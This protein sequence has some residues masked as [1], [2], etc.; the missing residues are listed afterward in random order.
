M[1]ALDLN[2]DNYDWNDLLNLFH[3]P[4]DFTEKQLKNAKQIVLKVHPDKSRL[5]PKYFLFFSKAYKT[6]VGIYEFKNKS[7]AERSEE[8]YANDTNDTSNSK[9]LDQFFSKNS[10]LKK[11]QEFNE[12]FNKQFEK[13]KLD[14]EESS[15]GYGSWLKSDEDV[16]PEMEEIATRAGM[17]KEI[18]R[19][20]RELRALVVQRDIEEVPCGS[21]GCHIAGDAPNE[22]SSDVFSRLQYQDLQQAHKVSV[23]P[24]TE[25]DY[26][27]VPKFAN[28]N[29]Y[30]LH[31]DAQ[32]QTLK[33]LSENQAIEYLKQKERGIEIESSRRAYKLMKQMEEVESKNSKFW[34][35]MQKITNQK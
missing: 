29:T 14:T 12:W 4:E 18:E 13:A 6:L 1:E 23:I 7:T 27:A 9:V 24:V 31:R 25:E 3:L 26:N 33:P 20:K 28:I 34:G 5:D 21:L 22:Y 17:E 10:S 8:S 2:I 11:G 19:R 35:S 16:T 30:K 15:K 32:T